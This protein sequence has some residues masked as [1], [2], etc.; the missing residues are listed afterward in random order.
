MRLLGLLTSWM[1]PEIREPVSVIRLRSQICVPAYRVWAD[2]GDTSC[3]PK[4][5]A[6]ILVGL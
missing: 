3:L 1:S 2:S 5:F 6:G 4:V